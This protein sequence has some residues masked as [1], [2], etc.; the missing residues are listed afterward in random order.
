MS[1]VV[2]YRFLGN[3]CWFWLL[4][5]SVVGLPVAFLYLLHGT[6]RIEEELNDP[7]RFVEEFRSGKLRRRSRG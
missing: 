3:S 7:E 1:K 4:C 2:R 5:V 6:I